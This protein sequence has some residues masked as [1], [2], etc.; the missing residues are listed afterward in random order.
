MSAL[1]KIIDS[2]VDMPGEFADVAAQGPAE[3]LLLAFG[4]LFVVLPSVA[5]GYLVLGAGL[6]LV[7]PS[8]TEIRHP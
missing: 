4:A 8:G 5:L 6:D 1:S 3:G 7:T 2:I